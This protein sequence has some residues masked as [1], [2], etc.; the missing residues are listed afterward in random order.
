LPMSDQS[1]VDLVVDADGIATLA[2]NRPDQ[3]G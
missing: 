2:Q 1:P 3:R